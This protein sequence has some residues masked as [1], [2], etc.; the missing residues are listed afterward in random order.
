MRCW[1]S[2]NWATNFLS[3]R[4]G[5]IDSWSILIERSLI[6]WGNARSILRRSWLT[7]SLN[8][9]PRV[10]L[11]IVGEIRLR[12]WFFKT[13]LIPQT[14]LKSCIIVILWSRLS[15]GGTLRWYSL[16]VIFLSRREVLWRPWFPLSSLFRFFSYDFFHLMCLGGIGELL[17]ISSLLLINVWFVHFKID[18]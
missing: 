1:A 14:W 18:F 8:I 7:L 9:S 5:S 2:I 17:L 12:F 6:R 15:R 3:I 13:Y 16:I 4:G 10:D 11:W